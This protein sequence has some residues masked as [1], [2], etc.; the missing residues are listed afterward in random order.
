M[1]ILVTPVPGL[2]DNQFVTIHL[3]IYTYSHHVFLLECYSCIFAIFTS[4]K[5]II[6][7]NTEVHIPLLIY[8][9]FAQYTNDKYGPVWGL[10]S[11]FLGIFKNS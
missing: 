6:K 4:K 2:S 10:S 8:H 11:L 3:S 9:C 1:E 5:K 7:I